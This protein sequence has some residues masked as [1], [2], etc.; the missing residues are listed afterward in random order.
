MFIVFVISF[1]IVI[2][3]IGWPAVY[4]LLFEIIAWFFVVYVIPDSV[5]YVVRKWMQQLDEFVE[6]W[7]R[8]NFRKWWAKQL[9]RKR[10]SP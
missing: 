10:Y 5:Y 1:V 8:W 4:V 6:D 7:K 2:C 3:F 9:N